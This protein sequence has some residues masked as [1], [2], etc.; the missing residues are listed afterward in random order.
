MHI[1]IEV[2]VEA[3]FDK[4]EPGTR[5]QGELPPTLDIDNIYIVGDKDRVDI[6]QR[7]PSSITNSILD[8]LWDQVKL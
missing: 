4:G 7:L 6:S 1:E 2:E 5:S 8:E 3:T